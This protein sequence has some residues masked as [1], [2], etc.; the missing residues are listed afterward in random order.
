MRRH[1]NAV[2][3]AAAGAV[4]VLLLS[5]CSGSGATGGA[6]T[7]GATTS[8]ATVQSTTGAGLS[9]ATGYNAAFDHIVNPSTKQGGTLN[10]LMASDFDS[11]DPQRSYAGGAWNM[12]RLY[13]R[14]LI[15]YK[16]VNGSK[17][18]LE[19]DLATNMG[20]HNANYT[21]WSYTLKPG[22]EWADGK[23][24]TAADIQWGISRLWASGNGVTGGPSSYFTSGLKAPKKYAGPYDSGP[25]TVGMTVSGDNKITFHLAGPNADFNYLM[26]MPASAPVPAKTE[27]GTGFVGADY[28]KH[29]MA[30]GPFEIQ[31]YTQNQQMV[32]VRNPHWKTRT[33]QIRRPLANK[34]VVTID[35][36]PDDI[37]QKLKA[38]TADGMT[39]G[40]VD[41]AFQAQILTNPTLKT[42][43]DDPSYAYT[44]YLTIQPSVIPNLHCRRA[45]FYAADKSQ[46]LRAFGG[47]TAGTVAGSMTPPGIAG[48]D[49]KLNPYPMGSGG[50]ADDAKAKEELSK[51][52]K[53]TGFTT[54]LAYAV[55]SSQR[56]NAF[57]A[58]QPELA[59]VGIKVIGATQNTSAFYTS[60]IGSPRNVKS[61]GLGI[62]MAGW[63]PD[64][65]TP[66]GFYQSIASGNAIAQTGNSNYPSLD[67]PV[68]NKIIDNGPS[69]N[70]TVAD[71]ARLNQQVM[72]DAVFDPMYWARS[73]YYRN[74]RLTNVTCDNAL[75]FGTYD[76]VNV[77]VSG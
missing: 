1:S 46:V 72:N 30:S 55:P 33:D 47:V 62:A 50:S 25:N 4:A 9:G 12:M 42:N 15:G 67:D 7:T 66:V 2:L 8:A 36:S 28:G 56:V 64:F 17:Y 20:T 5:D 76:W 32:F 37:G 26:A 54:K 11:W 68:V 51:C 29:P 39:N 35:S 61:Q 60:F 58:L 63:A 13:V 16:S 65:P 19:P 22:L 31:S 27:G 23:P 73:L 74:P 70:S 18:S 21:E 34:V 53:P 59:R 10:L 3:S 38:G 75:A 14:S 41:P 77:G 45:I 71:W 57:K 6:T 44:N 69:G 49:P 24:I 40:P 48:Y 43:A 52:G